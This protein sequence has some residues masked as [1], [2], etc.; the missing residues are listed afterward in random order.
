MTWKL[1]R[2]YVFFPQWPVLILAKDALTGYQMLWNMKWKTNMY[3]FYSRICQHSAFISSQIRPQWCMKCQ[4]KH[5]QLCSRVSETEAAEWDT[6]FLIPFTPL[7]FFSYSTT[8]YL[9]TLNTRHYCNDTKVM[10]EL[11]SAISRSRHWYWK[12]IWASNT[13]TYSSVQTLSQNIL[14]KSIL[15][16]NST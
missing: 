7:W 3:C 6:D 10:L 15:L 1:G 9:N 11:E 2:G 13:N 14:L 8:E 5:L 12:N 4:S 16:K